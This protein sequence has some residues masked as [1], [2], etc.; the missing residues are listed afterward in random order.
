[1]Q[2]AERDGTR[3]PGNPGTKTGIPVPYLKAW[4][5]TRGWTQADLVARAKVGITTL[6]RA[7]QPDWR[8]SLVVALKLA[9]ALGVSVNDLQRTDP[10]DIVE[11][12]QEEDKS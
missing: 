9:R 4:R 11:P 1:M 3:G 6:S 12:Q 5:V 2:V 10:L 7:E 8:I